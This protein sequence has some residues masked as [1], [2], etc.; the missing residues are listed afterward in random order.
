MTSHYSMLIRWS[1]EDAVFVVSLPEFG[2]SCNTH[3]TTYEEAV[4][5][6][7]D[8]L[9]LLIETYLAE[10]RPLPEPATSNASLSA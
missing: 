10:G 5:N 7:Q 1:D 3:G 2:E 9:D 6:G 8:V 4:K